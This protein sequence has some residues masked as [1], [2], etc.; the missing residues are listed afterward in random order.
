M[1]WKQQGLFF[2]VYQFFPLAWLCAV[3]FCG[4]RSDF[5]RIRLYWII[6]LN[7]REMCAVCFWGMRSDFNRIW[8]YWMI[9]LN[10]Q[11]MCAVYLPSNPVKC[12]PG[13][14]PGNK[15]NTKFNRNRKF[16][17]FLLNSTIPLASVRQKMDTSFNTNPNFPRFLLKRP[18]QSRVALS[19]M[20]TK[21]QE[22]ERYWQ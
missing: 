12:P 1:R 6:L 7:P 22:T 9:L 8:L 15:M 3:F 5:N 18:H 11:E 21:R 16:H 17:G 10:P 20:K 19:K 13:A 14:A 2:A 4:M